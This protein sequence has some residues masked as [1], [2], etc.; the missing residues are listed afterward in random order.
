MK[1]VVGI[2]CC[3]FD[4]KNQFVTDTYIRAIRI[5]GGTPLLIPVLPRDFALSPYLEICSGFLLPRVGDFT[6]FLFNE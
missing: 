2:L 6:T 5:S 3:G 1:P 4:G